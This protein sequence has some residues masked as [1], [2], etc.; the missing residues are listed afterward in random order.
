[1]TTRAAR[2]RGVIA[3]LWL[4]AGTARAQPG[5]ASDLSPGTQIIPASSLEQPADLA[6]VS[7]SPSGSLIAGLQSDHG[8]VFLLVSR[9]QDGQLRPFVSTYYLGRFQSVESY[10]WLTD[11][12]L[13]LQIEDVLSGLQ[14]PV[15][16]GMSDDTWRRLPL[17]SDLLRY[18][19]G[20]A[21]QALLQESGRDCRA[22]EMSFCVFSLNLNHW[23]GDLLSGP[24]RLLPVEFLP[25][26]PGDIYASG[27]TVQGRHAEY[28][29]GDDR[30]WRRVPDGTFAAQRA[31]L[32]IAQQ[33]PAAMMQAAAHVGIHHPTF[34]FT[35]PGH[36]LVG[37]IGRAPEPAFVALDPRLEGLHTFLARHYPTARVSIGGLDDA[38]THGQITVWDTD[39]PPTTFFL[40]P[41]GTLA[42][43]RPAN[44]HIQTDRLGQTHLEPLW[45]PGSSVA[46][47]MP[48]RG[49]Q[50]L[51]A[52]V[53]PVLAADSEL[54]DPLH[55]Y[56][57]QVQALAQRGIAVVRLL[58]PIPAS[59]ASNAAGAAWHEALVARLRQ[60]VDSASSNLLHGASVCLYGEGLAGELA[61][62]SGALAHVGC[63]VAVNPILN[64]RYLSNVNVTG[65]PV[66][67][68][69]LA[70]RLLGPTSAMLDRDFPAAFGNAQNQLNDS[71]SWLPGLPDRLMLGYDQDRYVDATRGYSVGD[72]AAGAGAFRRAARRAG[73]HLTLYM[74]DLR[75]ANFMQREAQMIDAVSRYV[76]GY[77][78]AQAADV[79]SA[80]GH[81]P[82]DGGATLPQPRYTALTAD[83]Y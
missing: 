22:R 72:F 5:A 35:T 8:Q 6:Q 59:F 58:A 51:G 41:D 76:Q 1:M 79:A 17:F 81:R 66:G 52:V 25:V 50:L 78:A 38:L 18:P 7:A 15:L 23:G 75:F 34:V 33:P 39:L 11:N 3:V 20:N 74:P 47:T 55:E 83:G 73:K 67:Y 12:Y 80:P 54:E 32:R 16:A 65:I 21:D 82:S 24:L 56:R 61:L 46:V 71:I 77:Y 45:S 37:V 29:L 13:L 44:P 48:P 26:A 64:A 9:W 2:F 30:T 53:T 57:P 68:A 4:L 70:F 49:R 60:V 27:R 19:W 31:A 40:E 36:R 10:R 14:I 43:Y 62:S 28:R 63:A 42:N 69:G